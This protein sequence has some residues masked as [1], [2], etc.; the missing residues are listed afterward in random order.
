MAVVPLFRRISKSTVL[1][2]SDY[3]SSYSAQGLTRTEAPPSGGVEGAGAWYV[4]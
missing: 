2:D 1:Y 4:D 3:K